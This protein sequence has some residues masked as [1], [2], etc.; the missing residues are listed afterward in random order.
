VVLLLEYDFRVAD[1]NRNELAIIVPI[2]KIHARRFLHLAFEERDEIITVE[3]DLKG[4]VA[5]LGAFQTF[6]NDVEITCSSKGRDQIVV[7]EHLIID[8]AGLDRAGPAVDHGHAICAFPVGQAKE[9]I[10]KSLLA[11]PHR[12]SWMRWFGPC[13]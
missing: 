6:G 11:F 10:I 5:D 7:L 1:A 3:M 2:E 8:G 4:L 9:A 13:P 12:L